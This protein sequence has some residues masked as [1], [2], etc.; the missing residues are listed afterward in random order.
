MLQEDTPA[1]RRSGRSALVSRNVWVGG[2]RTSI[3][4]ES[5]FWDLLE[6]VAARET[7]SIHDV[8]T[9]VSSRAEGYG[10]TGSIRVFLVSYAWTARMTESLESVPDG[11]LPQPRPAG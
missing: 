7:L 2:R 3:R 6:R 4:L 9:A 1:Q 5:V 10:L 11:R 8:C